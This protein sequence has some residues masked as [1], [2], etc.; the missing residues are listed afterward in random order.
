MRVQR[1]NDGFERRVKVR[2]IRFELLKV[3]Q[4]E[5]D[6]HLSD[7]RVLHGAQTHFIRVDPIA[8]S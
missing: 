2:I 3:V 5:L 8:V 4:E 1:L 6:L 7:G